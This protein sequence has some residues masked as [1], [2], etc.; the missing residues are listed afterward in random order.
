MGC[1]GDIA[2]RVDAAR[3]IGVFPGEGLGGLLIKLDVAK[4]L[5]FQVGDRS[6]DAMIDDISLEPAELAFDLINQD[7]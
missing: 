1:T 5:A 6:K 4:D 3:G 7:E 2:T